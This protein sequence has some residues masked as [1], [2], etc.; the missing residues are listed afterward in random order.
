M[1]IL[2]NSSLEFVSGSPQQTRRLGMRLGELLRGGELICLEGELG[3]G[4][5]CLAQGIGLGWGADRLLRSPSFTL[6]NEWERP[7][8]RQRLYHMDMYRLAGADEAWALGLAD[9]WEGED[10]CVIE[11]P[12]RVTA[13]LPGEFLWI[14]LSIVDDTRRQ[15][16]FNASGERY[17]KLLQRFKH[18]AF[19]G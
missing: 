7:G 2:N 5:T 17:K 11:W 13:L 1:P 19:G 8:D 16:I 10:V 9:L 12:E 4:K 6:I 14:T 18:V 15:Q 3:A